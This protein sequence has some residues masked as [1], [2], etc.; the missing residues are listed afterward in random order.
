MNKVILI[1]NL[2]RDPELSNVGA[3]GIPVCRFSIAVNRRA[4]KDG[5]READF[6]NISAWRG[7]GEN[8][9]KYL[10]KGRKVG[11]T[12]ELQIR[13]YDDKDGN[14]RTAVDVI[15]DEVEF[16]TAKGDSTG[17]GNDYVAP[18]NDSADSGEEMR[19]VTDDS[20]PF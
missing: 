11:V 3:D 13:N 2:T 17:G 14:K 19:P 18:S 16:L 6:F 12:G 4:K 8:C 5:T 7:L 9:Q 20:L 10:A 15:A 1:G